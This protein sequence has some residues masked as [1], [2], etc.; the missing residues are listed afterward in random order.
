MQIV[1]SCE[2]F[3][4]VES[5][6]RHEFLDILYRIGPQT[7]IE[8]TKV[9]HKVLPLSN[10]LVDCDTE[11]V[12]YIINYITCGIS[13]I[14]CTAESMKVRF[15]NHKS[16]IKYA[17]RTCE[18]SIHFSENQGVHVFDKS[19]PKSYD[20]TL[21][22]QLEVIIIEKVDVSG[23]G[24]DTQSRLKQCKKREYYWQNQLKTPRQYGGMNVREEI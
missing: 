23:V 2:A 18:V 10:Q 22:G 15:R 3:N 7:E 24:T 20:N 21:K 1:F 5:R 9:T 12:I 13:S 16:H 19:T 17:R 11:N 4:R 8:S 6:E 14:G